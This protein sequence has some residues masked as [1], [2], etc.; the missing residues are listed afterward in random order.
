ML[1]LAS[2]R[3]GVGLSYGLSE[4]RP[5]LGVICGLLIWREFKGAGE[6]PRLLMLVMLILMAGGIALLAISRG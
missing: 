2:P 1:A 5:V 6:R 3:N 4:S